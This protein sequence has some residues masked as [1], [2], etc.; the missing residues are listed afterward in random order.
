MA[1]A[2][3]AGFARIER[4]PGLIGAKLRVATE[5]NSS[6]APSDFE[7]SLVSTETVEFTDFR[8]SCCTAR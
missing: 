5:T 2:G 6:C 3:G 1:V 8:S 4:A 7:D